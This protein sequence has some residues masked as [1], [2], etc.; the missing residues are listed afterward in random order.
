M[1]CCVSKI[2]YH[3]HRIGCAHTIAVAEKE[4]MLR[5]LVHKYARSQRG[6]NMTTLATQDMPKGRGKK[7]TKAT[8]RRKGRAGGR[9]LVCILLGGLCTFGRYRWRK[10]HKHM[11]STKT[12]E[13]KIQ[14]DK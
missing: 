11:L 1:K 5:V 7:A 14:T 8:Q 13:A 12:N 4:G 10:G 2:V 6:A 3:G 9:G